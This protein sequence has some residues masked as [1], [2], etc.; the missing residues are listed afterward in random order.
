[1]T[2]SFIVSS[3]SVILKQGILNFNNI[4]TQ[5][6]KARNNAYKTV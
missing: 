2:S 3:K 4:H 1:M 6:L 5:N